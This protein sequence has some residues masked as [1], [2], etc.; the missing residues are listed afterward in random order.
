MTDPVI[1]RLVE[2]RDT[3]IDRLF[4]FV[5]HPSVG[6]DP[7]Y[8]DGMRGAQEFLLERLRG[9]GFCNVGGSRLAVIRPFMGNGSPR[10]A[11]PP[12]WFM[13]T[14]MF[15]RPIRLTNG[16]RPRSS[17]RCGTIAST[18]AASRTTRVR[19]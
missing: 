1:V 9:I 5:R 2:E 11:S 12:S 14:M 8:A 16:R 4:A 3:I 15:N 6:A 19:A 18:P 13:A 17:Q 7:A 10:R